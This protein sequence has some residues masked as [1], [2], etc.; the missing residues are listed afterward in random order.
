MLPIESELL[1]CS[2]LK[3]KLRLYNKSTIE[4]DR[5]DGLAVHIGLT[6]NKANSL[7]HF[8]SFQF[9]SYEFLSSPTKNCVLT[10]ALKTEYQ[11]YDICSQ[12]AILVKNIVEEGYIN[13]IFINDQEYVVSLLFKNFILS[14]VVQKANNI[15]EHTN[16]NINSEDELV[17]EINSKSE[18]TPK[19]NLLKSSLQVKAYLDN[20]REQILPCSNLMDSSSKCNAVANKML[21]GNKR[22]KEKSERTSFSNLLQVEFES[23]SFE[24]MN[25]F[26]SGTIKSNNISK[27]FKS[28]SSHPKIIGDKDFLNKCNQLIEN[29]E[30]QKVIIMLS[31]KESCFTEN[32][33]YYYYLGLS[34]FNLNNQA[35]ARMNFK[36]SLKIKNKQPLIYFYLTSSCMTSKLYSE[37]I[38]YVNKLIAFQPSYAHK[39]MKAEA[40]LNL[41]SWNICLDIVEELCKLDCTNSKAFMIKAKVL[42]IKK[43]YEGALEAISKSIMYRDND[44]SEQYLIE[45]EIYLKLNQIKHAFASINNCLSIDPKS[46]EAMLIKAEV[47]S[48]LGLPQEAR[49]LCEQILEIIPN[50]PKRRNIRAM[51]RKFSN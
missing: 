34:Y 44:C 26:E 9:N 25:S 47:L 8:L 17:L 2:L 29:S 7:T 5:G 37:A 10:E 23:D 40:L 30:F 42:T 32:D 11:T 24:C 46:T 28:N 22:K 18:K 35:K 20:D 14:Y 39:L 4:F 15:I 48:Q 16:Q 19:K 36:K 33:I 12:I 41:G 31:S 51:V 21:I 6:P 50:H 13:I 38:T 1:Y 27:K 3:C 49:K 45:S 43:D